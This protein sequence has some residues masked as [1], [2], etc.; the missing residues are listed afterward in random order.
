MSHVRQVQRGRSAA[1]CLQYPFLPLRAT[2]VLG[3]PGNT[4]PTFILFGASCLGVLQTTGCVEYT[5]ARH[6]K[7][8]PYLPPFL[9][10]NSKP[11]LDCTSWGQADAPPNRSIAT[12]G[13]SALGLPPPSQSVCFL[14]PCGGAGWFTGVWGQCSAACGGGIQ[15]RTVVCMGP[16]GLPDL[17]TAC[18]GAGPSPPNWQECN[19][20]QCPK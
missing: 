15:N 5:T 9:Y 7:K 17:A 8:S 14:R 20:A 2:P 4:F 13:C 11:V 1:L 6:D 3:A 10:G 19:S 16:D 12:V 18:A